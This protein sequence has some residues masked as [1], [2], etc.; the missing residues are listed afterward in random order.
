LVL[1]PESPEAVTRAVLERYRFKHVQDA[2]H[3]LLALATEKISFLASHRCRHFLAAIA[4]PLLQAIAATPDPDSTL[5]DLSKISDSLGGKGVLWE[6]FSYHPP[7][8]QLYV[9]LCAATP[10]L[11]GILTSNPGMIDE[12]M[13]SLVLDKL[14]TQAWLDTMLEDLLHGAEDIEP[15][16]HGFKNSLHLRVGVRDVLGKE[17]I[18][19]T[20]RV[21]SDIAEVCLRRIAGAEYKRLCTK[22]GTPLIRSEDGQER[23]CEMVILALGKLG[24]REPNY[25]SDLDV[26]FLY[27][28]DGVTQHAFRGRSEQSTTNQHFFTQLA[29]RI[30]K[31]LSQIGPLG[32]LYELDPRLRPTGRSGALAV[33]L[34][35]FTRYFAEGQGQVW[36]RQ[37]LC[38]ARAISGSPA[39]SQAVMQAVHRAI[40]GQGWQPGYADEI[41]RMRQRLEETA[42]RRNLKRGPGGTVDIEFAVQMLQLKYAADLP[43]VLQPGT[44][45]AIAAL[46][47]AGCLSGDDSE[48]LSRSYRFLR[49]IE[50]RLRLMNTAARHDLP[51]DETELGKLAYLLDYPSVEAL[52][53]E[54]DHFMQDN[55]RRCQRLFGGD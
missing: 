8:L 54:C 50:A 29:Q 49:S 1:D 31:V 12:L 21:L 11:S 45:D 2:Y 17:D 6:L 15:I 35:E 28:S 16:L 41:R 7:S 39:A 4:R 3:H 18:R 14:P 20:H 40:V 43:H 30:I 22:H 37:A 51:S 36:E 48:C 24:G 5:V 44:L 55:R 46:H 42:T 33:S 23:P 9:R 34:D 47:E 19:N 25:H 52:Q 10:Y 26:V 27:E 38:K 32:R 53:H 13:D